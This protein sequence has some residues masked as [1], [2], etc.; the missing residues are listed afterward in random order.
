[1]TL[2]KAQASR[3]IVGQPDTGLPQA[4]REIEELRNNPRESVMVLGRYRE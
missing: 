4:L 2:T 1:M 3:V